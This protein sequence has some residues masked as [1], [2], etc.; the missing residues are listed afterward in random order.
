MVVTVVINNFVMANW[1][2]TKFNNWGQALL[3]KA[4]TTDDAILA[5]RYTFFGNEFV[6]TRLAYNEYAQGVKEFQGAYKAG[7]LIFSCFSSL[8]W[9]RLIGLPPTSRR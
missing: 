2:T 3:K 5:R 8:P 1:A 7:A 6:G 4:V 9:S